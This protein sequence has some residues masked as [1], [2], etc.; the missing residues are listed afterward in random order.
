MVWRVILPAVVAVTFACG[1]AWAQPKHD[2]PTQT[3]P[4]KIR[5]KLA[6][7]GYQDVK[8]TPGSFIVSAKDKDGHRVMMLIGPTSM[9]MMKVP[10]NP[11]I[12]Q[13][14]DNKDEIIQQ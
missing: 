2:D 6:A 7:E 1:A 8:V 14:P 13:T 5:D 3:L 12:A 4:D 9:T 11:S 10:D